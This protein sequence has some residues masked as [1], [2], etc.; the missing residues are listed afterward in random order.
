MRIC[1]WWFHLLLLLAVGY[2]NFMMQL[3][4]NVILLL[5]KLYLSLTVNYK[6]FST[7]LII[8]CIQFR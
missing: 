1:L 2:L 4:Y 7:A 3:S 6:L 8:H 5:L